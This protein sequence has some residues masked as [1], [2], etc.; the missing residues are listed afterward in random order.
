MENLS[1]GQY[2]VIDLESKQTE[3]EYIEEDF[4]E[5]NIGGAKAN[6]ALFKEYED[7][8][9]IVLGTGLLTGTLVPGSALG[10]ITGKSPITGKV[11]HA[12]FF[13]WAGSELKYSG[14]DYIVIKGKA[15]NPL[16]LWV[17]DG[18]VDLKDA[19]KIWETDTWNTVDHLRFTLGEDLIQILSIGEAGEKQVNFSQIA[20]N[21]W[22]SGDRFA[23]GSVLGGKNLKAIALRGMGTLE[24]ASER[25]FV[26]KCLELTKAVSK[27][28]I[29][30]KKGNVLFPGHLG[31]EPV[32]EWIEPLVHRYSGCFACPYSCNTYLKYHESPEVM[33]ETKIKEPGVMVTDVAGLMG[34]KEAGMDAKESGMAIEVCARI[35]A[36]PVMISLWAKE[37]GMTTAEEL[38]KAIS[39]WIAEKKSVEYIAPWPVSDAAAKIEAEEGLYSP[40]TL[41][42]PIF[43]DFGLADDAQER[44]DWWKRRNTMAYNLG[45]CP[46]LAV[47]SPELEAEVLSEL[48]ELG[49]GIEMDEEMFSNI[50]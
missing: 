36:N 38:S 28:A 39:S 12:P 10:I 14:F 45:I 49:T 26:N 48:I 32:N 1:S 7:E 33:K 16:Y 11:C 23:L 22:N 50:E 34:F 3:K 15:E 18:M 24:I 5:K 20:L 41:P 9:P 4:F 35:G 29:S 8:D 46:I 21:Y 25:E 44:A 31:L 43:S 30:D 19:Y 27:G 47:L 2:V 17:H 37:S 13:L 42:Q 40:W 6:M